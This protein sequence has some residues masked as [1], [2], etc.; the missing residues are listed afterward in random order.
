MMNNDDETYEMQ[1]QY[2]IAVAGS[3][4]KFIMPRKLLEMD[5]NIKDKSRGITREAEIKSRIAEET[6]IVPEEYVPFEVPKPKRDPLEE[7]GIMGST[8][9]SGSRKKYG[10]T[11]TGYGAKSG[12]KKYH[13]KFDFL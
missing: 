8:T 6:S 9:G 3:D 1:Y 11:K 4:I 10:G 2:G 7:L 5:K 12:K 13:K